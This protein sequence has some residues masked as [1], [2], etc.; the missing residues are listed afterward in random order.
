VIESLHPPATDSEKPQLPGFWNFWWMFWMQPILLHQRLG[1]CGIDNPN[2]SAIHIWRSDDRFRDIRRKYVVRL[3]AMLTL[4]TPTIAFLVVGILRICG[5]TL[6]PGA[7]EFGIV[8]GVTGGVAVGVADGI[9]FGVAGGVAFGIAGGV[10]FGIAGDIGVGVGVSAAISVGVGVGVGAGI[11]VGVSVAVGKAVHLQFAIYF[12]VISGIMSGFT[13][14]SVA[15]GVIVGTAVSLIL[16]RVPI[17]PFEL[18]ACL[19]SQCAAR[20]YGDSV[21]RLLPVNWHDLSYIPMPGL[22]Q[23]LLTEATRDPDM[24]RR[25]LEACQ[26]SPSQREIGRVVLS[27][28]KVREWKRLIKDRSFTDASELR[29]NWLEGEQE[30]DS[31][32]RALAEV[33]RYLRAA[34][35]AIVAQ[36]RSQQVKRAKQKLQQMHIRLLTD[37]SSEVPE[38]QLSLFAATLVAAEMAWEAQALAA[39]QVPNPFRAGDPLTPEFDPS[40]FRGREDI[41]RQIELLLNDE[42]QA[43]AVSVLAPRRC[44]KSSLLRMLP[45]KL[46]DAL[47]VFFDLQDNP[48]QAPLDLFPALEKRLR[49]QARPQEREGLPRLRDSSLEAARD[50]LEALEQRPGRDRVLLCLDEFERLEEAVRLKPEAMQQLV[51]LMGLLRAT[52]QHRRRVRLLVAGNS[53][54]EELGPLWNDSFISARELRLGPLERDVAIGLLRQPIPVEE[55][56]PDDA[57]PLDVAEAIVDRTGGQPYLTQLY[58]FWLVEELNKTKR[59]RAELKDVEAVD[60]IVFEQAAPFFRDSLNPRGATFAVK[61]VIEQIV[62]GGTP[63]L[64]G[65]QSRFLMR[66]GLITAEGTLAFPI[67]ARWLNE[68]A[69]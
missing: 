54:F 63:E 6:Q 67:L 29:G 69:E 57:V 48:I 34:S 11:W 66:R 33:S 17:L 4:G 43:A 26:R 27:I 46:P 55:G 3:A 38:F 51:Q 62:A 30:S 53:T 22:R 49:E 18:I 52:I 56:F 44:G 5:V 10:A 25:T 14:A 32:L 24:V 9:V 60:Q 21:L 8:V 61:P 41:V 20:V 68:Y 36:H 42:K 40:T 45:V 37:R 13:G 47:C 23:Q 58:G 15:V 65:N 35:I 64:T 59:K 2:A 7:V 16:L 31:R 19:L 39:G 12:G 50:W 28:L 1:E